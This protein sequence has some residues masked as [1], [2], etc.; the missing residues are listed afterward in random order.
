MTDLL[1]VLGAALVT[2][3]LGSAHCLGMCAGIS[4]MVAVG[5]GVTGLKTQLPLSIAYNFGRILSYALLGALAAAAGDVFV[6]AVP[7]MAKPIRLLSGAIIV[8]IGLQLAFNWQFLAPIER[9]GSHLWKG[10]API[11]QRFVP[12]TSLPRAMGLGLLWGFLPC[13][14]VYSVLLIAATTANT[15]GGAVTMAAFGL[16]TMPAMIFTGVTAFRLSQ[17]I[18]RARVAAGVL[19]I[20]IGLLTLAMPVQSW[21]MPAGMHHH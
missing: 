6:G 5:S 16:G 2:G 19:M 14:L 10:V 1:P 21:L 15:A 8:L 4:G 17:K 20:L 9:A 18:G 11:A 7:A 13:G 12:V 3:L